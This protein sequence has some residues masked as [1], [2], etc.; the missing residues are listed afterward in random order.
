MQSI[1]R[2][3]VRPFTVALKG[4]I[5]TLII[6]ATSSAW[7]TDLQV[8]VTESNVVINNDNAGTFDHMTFNVT[9]PVLTIP[10]SETL[11]LGTKIELT[12]ISFGK[13]AS[14]NGNTRPHTLSIIGSNGTTYTSAAI[15]ESGTFTNAGCTKQVYSFSGKGCVLT[16]G[17]S[18]AMSFKNSDGSAFGTLVGRTAKNSQ[19]MFGTT[20]YNSSYTVWLPV[21]EL[22]GTI[23]G[24]TSFTLWTGAKTDIYNTDTSK[25]LY[26]HDV[27]GWISTGTQSSGE[28]T[29]VNGPA[30]YGL[31][32]NNANSLADNNKNRVS[33]WEKLSGDGTLTTG[34]NNGQ[35]PAV[36]IYDASDFTGSIN[37]SADNVYLTV[38][39]CSE[40]DTFSPNVYDEIGGKLGLIYIKQGTSVTV[41]KGATWSARYGIMNKGNLTINGS[42]ASPISNNGG[43]VT[44]N[45]GATLASFGEVR[46]FTGFT[47]DS[48]VEVKIK[49]TA[50]EYGKGLLNVTGASGISSITV[51]APDGTTVVTTVTP[52]NGVAT[53]NRGSVLVSGKAC[54][55]DYEMN[56]NLDNAGTDTTGL[57]YDSNMNAGNSFY[58]SQMLYTYTHPYRGVTYPSTWTAVVR[59]TVPKVANGAVITFGTNGG[60]LIGL[61]A[62]DNP[63]KEMKLIK[64]TGNVPY[65]T[66]ATMP[67]VNGTTAQHVYV[68]AVENNSTI[69][70][71]CDGSVVL[72]QTFDSQFT[73][74]RGIQV[75][76]VHG[77][78]YAT[79]ITAVWKGNTYAGLTDADIQDARIDCVRLY[80][81]SLSA[82]Q[83]AA[84]SVEFPAVKLYQAMVPD[85]ATTTWDA[86]SW[87]PEWDG[88][89]SYSKI[90]LTA[91][92]NGSLTFPS[93]ITAE[94]FTIDIPVGKVLNISKAAPSE[95]N[96]QH[97]TT[98]SLTNP[99]EIKGGSVAFSE[100]TEGSTMDLDFIVGGNGS[101][102]IDSGKT[103]TVKDGGELTK[104]TG[105]GTVVYESLPAKALSF[106]NWTGTVQ[107]PSIT[108]GEVKLN[109]YGVAGSKVKLTGISGGAWLANALVEPTIELGGDVTLSGFSTSFAN[110]ITKLTGN[111]TF[112]L[113]YSDALTDDAYKG[114][115][116]IKDVSEF[117]GRFAVV[118][119]GLVLGGDERPNI[120]DWYG[121]IVVQGEMKPPCTENNVVATSTAVLDYTS[122]DGVSSPIT[123][124]LNVDSSAQFKFPANA[125]F[126]YK[127]A[128]SSSGAIILNAGNYTIGG[129]VGTK[130]LTLGS[131]GMACPEADTEFTGGGDAINWTDLDWGVNFSDKSN[132]DGVDC[133]VAVSANGTLALGTASARKVT[134]ALA[135][136]TTLTLTGALNASEISFV[137]NGTVVCSAANTLQGTI[138]GDATITIEYP[139][140]T[141]PTGAT[142]TNAA[143][144]GTLVLTNCGHLNSDTPRTRVR[145]PFEEFG[146]ANSKIRA[147][148]FKGFAAVANASTAGN[149]YCAATLV[150]EASDVFEFNHGWQAQCDSDIYA[151]N[152]NAGYKFAKLAGTGR[153]FLDGTTDYAQYIFTDVRGFTG[154]VDITFP[155]TGGRKSYIFGANGVLG[156]SVPANLVIAANTSA[157]VSAGKTWDIPA[158]V[159][160]DNGATL[161]LGDGSTATVLSSR[162]E[163]TLAVAASASATVTNIMDS[164][165]TAKLNI[166]S[167]A[168]L[169]ITDTSLTTLTLPADVPA[170]ENDTT[171]TYRNNGT[172]DLTGCTALTKLY[173][174]LGES[175]TVD[176]TGNKIKL[177]TACK[178]VY[179]NIGAKRTLTDYT[180]PSV[181]GVTFIY[182]AEETAAE[183]ANG[184]FE[185]T[186]VPNG[187]TMILKRRS[188]MEIDTGN[189][190]TT[191]SY[192]GG[193]SFAGAACWHEWDFEQDSDANK[194]EDTG[195]Y[196]DDKADTKVGYM[197]PLSLPT[198]VTPVYSTVKAQGRTET[199]HVISAASKPFAAVP[200]ETTWSA[201][202]RCTM[203]STAGQV[204]VAFGD[205]TNGILGLASGSEAGVVDLFNWTSTG[206]YTALAQFKVE[207]PTSDMHIYVFTVEDGTVSLYRDGEFIHSAEFTTS[208]ITRFMVGDICGTRGALEGLPDPAE[209]D[210][211][212]DSVNEAG[213]VDYIRL[214]YTILPQSDIEGLSRRRPFVSAIDSFERTLGVNDAWNEAGT[215]TWTKANGAGVVTADYPHI[216]GANVTV[217][218]EDVTTLSLNLDSDIK[219]GT[220]KFT[221]TDIISLVQAGTG[222]IG[223]EM[224]V[225]RSGAKLTAD[226]NAVDFSD[227]TVGVDAGAKLT[228]NLANFA[229]ETIATN[230]VVTLIRSVP[231][232]GNLSVEERAARYAIIKPAPL[233][234]NIS[235]IV[236]GWEGNSYVVTITTT[237]QAGVDPVYY[238]EGA[239]AGDMGVYLVSGLTGDPVRVIA[240]DNVYIT[241]DSASDDVSVYASFDGNLVVER[242]TL[243]ITP[244][245]EGAVL[246]GSTITVA[247]GCTVVFGRGDYGAMTLAKLGTGTGRFVFAEDATV[248]SLS[249]NV[250]IEVADGVTLTLESI[251]TFVTGGVGGTGTVKLPAVTGNINLNLY[252]NANSTVELTSLTDGVLVNAAVSP[253]LNVAGTV[254]IVPANNTAYSFSKVIGSGSLTFNVDNAPESITIGE[255]AEFASTFSI[256]NVDDSEISKVDIVVSTLSLD[257]DV[258]FG[259]K[260]LSKTGSVIVGA[261]N[262]RGVPSEIVPTYAADGVYKA[263]ATYASTGYKSFGDVIAAAGDDLANIIVL[264]LQA[265]SG[266]SAEY[267]V[268]DSQLVVKPTDYTWVGNDLDSWATIANWRFGAESTA[269]RLPG[270]ADRAIFASDARITVSG[271]VSVGAIVCSD[272]LTLT[273][274][275]SVVMLDETVIL[276]DPDATITVPSSV[277]L[278]AT[279]VIS[280]LDAYDV[281]SAVDGSGNTTYSLVKKPGTIFSVW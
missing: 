46:D 62:G 192:T 159:I 270:S 13:R 32:V 94:D 133:T 181:D 188:G 244:A 187:V 27:T 271:V 124:D 60:G 259:S 178:T 119:P 101:V 70:V 115:F 151:E 189:T 90:V 229:F 222:A 157:T 92:G 146:S 83:I 186:A 71:Y 199:F 25:P 214:Y 262:I 140:K 231:E 224:L 246:D 116:L 155:G 208:G 35:T 265:T 7:A 198:G 118:N 131:D 255:V 251:V 61:I 86:L 193:R 29:L 93:T 230:T 37:A 247:D 232:A 41:A 173:L 195:M 110:T 125:A 250:S 243:S 276:N 152:E 20:V 201:A 200:F 185:A 111:Y 75:G 76:S 126:P 258:A 120:N 58:N 99:L 66:L 202:V 272:D 210:A 177:P 5:L 88:G 22:T 269:T 182:Y 256:N 9:N 245:G 74:G 204:A 123:G 48:S 6:C 80:N 96:P 143:W 50:E 215:W 77:G 28:I 238:K 89:N 24:S 190:G 81:Y 57:S 203:P 180:V 43:T 164:V 268:S 128:K 235:S 51:L 130:R 213:Y 49:M 249:G 183:Y 241:N 95:E 226:Y 19:S 38:I 100:T 36:K 240:G 107:L 280:G 87:T 207:S 135:S 23:V 82:A 127:L 44:V 166:G 234:A 137:G 17:L 239:I 52:E 278:P 42:V 150:I 141:L 145:V 196:S 109:E 30:G 10:A 153:L 184:V 33:V 217:G 59:C 108:S 144:E 15:S 237:H 91:A 168:T 139:D 103:I 64:T 114:Y 11:P 112:S 54:W 85:C 221:G 261:V 63:E 79:G 223:A 175:K 40:N 191:R 117:T 97:G 69:K 211:E 98:F 225:V 72:N 254:T 55:C 53:Y 156:A 160:I 219:Y 45:E 31:S 56:G 16:V 158:G 132:L 142:W 179:L 34:H 8:T 252:G 169:N 129:V 227:S 3:A 104:I 105:S 174:V 281:Q 26:L 18:Y 218:S 106:N 39:F 122:T 102:F 148:G 162:S 260:M 212:T 242:T 197:I 264:D 165:M 228:F 113:T 84:L 14:G 194:L 4:I 257:E 267:E 205:T 263:V 253:T 78:I 275:G 67:I 274:D 206:G 167:G 47:V 273:G 176:F 277:V 147:P 1:V 68:F 161:N 134:F 279:A 136:G 172:L 149:A 138:K 12:S 233:P 266:L 248:A 2:K 216:S 220:L 121:K 209:D 171:W 21:Q 170:D 73:I 236:D 163:G 65:E 154:T